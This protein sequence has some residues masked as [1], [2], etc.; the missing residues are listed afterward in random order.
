MYR[1]RLVYGAVNLS[2]RK[3]RIVS[4]NK[5]VPTD[6]RRCDSRYWAIEKHSIGIDRHYTPRLTGGYYKVVGQV[7]VESRIVDEPVA[8]RCCGRRIVVLVV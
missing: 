8:Q 7:G 5:N 3:A 6:G 2:T 1:G 4:V